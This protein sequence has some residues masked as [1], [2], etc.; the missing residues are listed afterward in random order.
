LA[1]SLVGYCGV[2]CLECQ[3]YISSTTSDLRVKARLAQEL[4]KSQDQTRKQ[5]GNISPDSIHC[6]GCRSNSKHCW[7]KRCLFKKC[8]ADKGFDFCYQ[9]SEF[10]CDEL[11]QFYAQRPNG[12]DNLAL[13][14]KIGTEA[15]ISRMS[16][17]SPTNATDLEGPV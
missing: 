14:S 1:R 13:I 7:K 8:A 11:A 6:W 3:I 2:Y 4:S 9:C 15:F 10:P 16:G 17:R 5:V 12:R